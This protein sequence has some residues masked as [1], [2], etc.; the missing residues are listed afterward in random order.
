MLGVFSRQTGLRKISLLLFSFLLLISLIPSARAIETG[1]VIKEL[2]S[3]GP[4]GVEFRDDCLSGFVLNSLK[5][6][7]FT[8]RNSQAITQLKGSC[9]EIEGNG[10]KLSTNSSFT[11]TYGLSIAGS[12][13]AIG[14]PRNMVATGVIVFNTS[15][16]VYVSGLKLLCGE[17]PFGENS[18]VTTTLGQETASSEEL[19]CPVNSL[20]SGVKVKYGEIVD[21]FGIL[22]SKVIGLDQKPITDIVIE[23]TEQIYPYSTTVTI[24]SFSG[25]SGS[26]KVG[27]TSAISR[28]PNSTC[29]FSDG[30]VTASAATVCE[31]TITKEGDGLYSAISAK[32]PLAFLKAKQAISINSIG[33]PA[34]LQNFSGP[35]S[36]VISGALG[37]GAITFVVRNGSAEGCSLSDSSSQGTIS[38]TS[39]GTCIVVANIESDENYEAASSPEFLVDMSGQDLAVSDQSE[40]RGDLVFR[41]YDP[42]QDSENVVD[43]QVAA[44]ALLTLATSAGATSFPNS[45]NNVSSRTITGRKEE[46]NDQQAQQDSGSDK[47]EGSDTRESGDIA[48][49]GANKLSF[50]KRTSGLGDNSRLWKLSHAPKLENRFLSLI[51]GTSS[52]SPVAARIFQDGSYLRAMFS[53]ISLI[54][55]FAGIITSIFILTDTKFQAIPPSTSLLLL[56]LG[57]STIDALAGLTISGIVLIATLLSKNVDSLDEAMTLIGIAGLILTPALIASSIRPLRRLITDF[58]SRW[59][60]LTDYFLAILIGGWSVEKLVGALN[61]LAGI[62]FP[63]ADQARSIGATVSIFLF[64]RLLLEDIA[65]H[66]FP[67]RL[68]AQEANVLSPRAAQPLFSLLIKTSLFFLVAYQFLGL[69]KQLLLGTAIFVLPQLLNM[70]L[71]N[72]QIKKF[73]FISFLL[74]KGAPKLVIMVFIGAFFANWMKSLFADPELFITWS[75]VLLAIP[76]LLLSLLGVISGSPKKDWKD[77]KLGTAIYRVGGLMI[78]FLIVLMYQGVDLYAL[79]FGK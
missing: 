50:F 71:K 48:S 77:G 44:F 74:P 54:P 62:Q 31:L 34:S 13:S 35:L 18:R 59:E 16:S 8:W 2:V 19:R 38:S 17:L 12:P 76:G 20:V 57:L 68:S 29:S 63:I 33:D 6:N 47:S 72:F 28:D 60:R 23:P 43:F 64:I 15:G 3:S 49:T 26:G 69:N 39:T 58:S 73:S 78:G 52:F 79:T 61:G 40:Q 56:A 46:S 53:G 5:G 11:G 21:S 22:C 25:G 24:K 70:I 67:E 30:N 9:A 32:V 41:K 65:T 1:K 66:F 36:P 42:I 45:S 37:K 14:C 51:E 7:P 27:I 75:F 10:E 55:I 4:G